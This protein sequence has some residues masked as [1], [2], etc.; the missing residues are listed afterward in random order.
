MLSRLL[1]RLD[2]RRR[3]RLGLQQ[4][5]ADGVDNDD[6]GDGDERGDQAVLDRGGLA[7]HPHKHFSHV[8]FLNSSGS[9]GWLR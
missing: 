4:R 3:L 1:A 7:G 6:D 5:A 9:L 2:L 8:V